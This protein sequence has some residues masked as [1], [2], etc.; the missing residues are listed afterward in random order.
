MATL[1]VRALLA[2]EYLQNA[3]PDGRWECETV[4]ADQLIYMYHDTLF[5]RSVQVRFECA[6]EVLHV[7]VGGNHGRY[8]KT[9]SF[10]EF[11]IDMKNAV[12]PGKYFKLVREFLEVEPDWQAVY[13]KVSGDYVIKLDEK[14]TCERLATILLCGDGARF[15]GRGKQTVDFDPPTSLDELLSVVYGGTTKSANKQ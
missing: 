13:Y 8:H 12:P 10:N 4:D 5:G 11:R 6:P 14:T 7:L 3:V 1:P 15:V 2:L 9:V